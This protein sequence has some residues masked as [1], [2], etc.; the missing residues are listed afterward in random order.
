MHE[1]VARFARHTL[2]TMNVNPIEAA[3]SFSCYEPYSA[4]KEP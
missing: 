3:L 4:G 1:Q 2:K